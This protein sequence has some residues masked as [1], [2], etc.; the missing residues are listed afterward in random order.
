MQG[1]LKERLRLTLH[2]LKITLA[3]H[4]Q[5]I[6]WLGYHLFFDHRLL[7]TTTKRRMVKRFQTRIG[8]HIHG[9]ISVE[10]LRQTAASYIGMLAHA[11]QYRL[12]MA[13]SKLFG[14]NMPTLKR[15]KNLFFLKRANKIWQRKMQ[16]VSVLLE[17]LN[18]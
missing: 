14:I 15:V 17:S 8:E 2:P 7:R 11:T 1:F 4:Q 12:S 16:R 6:D 3:P 9:R 13:I 10:Q 5:G 18:M